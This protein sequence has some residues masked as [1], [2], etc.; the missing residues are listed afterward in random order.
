MTRAPGLAH[1]MAPVAAIP[2]NCVHVPLRLGFG[3][4]Y[5]SYARDYRSAQE[6]LAAAVAE[7][8][9]ARQRAN[10]LL[11]HHGQEL[12]KRAQPK[13]GECPATEDCRYYQAT[14]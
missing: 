13:C 14:R 12:C 7:S 6:S 3:T 1:L 9:E 10:L 2:S 4:A 8:C 5:K 11:Q